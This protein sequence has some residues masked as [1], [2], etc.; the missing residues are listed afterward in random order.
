VIHSFFF[1]FQELV[2][3]WCD[4]DQSVVVWVGGL[5]AETPWGP[6]QGQR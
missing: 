5:G 4:C 2:G 3:G 1:N 6:S